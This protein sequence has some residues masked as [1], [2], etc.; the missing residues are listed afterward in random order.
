[1]PILGCFWQSFNFEGGF[2]VKILSSFLV[3]V[4]G[5][6]GE[7]IEEAVGSLLEGRGDQDGVELHGF[8]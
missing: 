2:S 3:S 5:G 8:L 1:M 6:F 7:V 4:F